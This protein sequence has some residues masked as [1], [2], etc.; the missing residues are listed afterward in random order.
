MSGK[1]HCP[2]GVARVFSQVVGIGLKVIVIALDIKGKFKGTIAFGAENE[3]V[4]LFHAQVIAVN[5]Q[6]FT[7]LGIQSDGAF[8]RSGWIDYKSPVGAFFGKM[9]QALSVTVVGVSLPDFVFG[10]DVAQSF[11]VAKEEFIHRF[12]EVGTA[13]C[14]AGLAALFRTAQDSCT[15]KQENHKAERV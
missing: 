6:P 13:D 5:Y 1:R 3:I 11:D 10:V 12:S 7:F 2:R 14:C 15:K 9:H 4:S 8:G